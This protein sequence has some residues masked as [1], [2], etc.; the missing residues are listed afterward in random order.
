MMSGDCLNL[1]IRKLQV[2]SSGNV[3]NVQLD[4]I[5]IVAKL[6]GRS[7]NSVNY[8]KCDRAFS[9]VEYHCKLIW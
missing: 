8:K 3:V 1:S 7:N 5:S 2:S 4:V 6:G 9:W